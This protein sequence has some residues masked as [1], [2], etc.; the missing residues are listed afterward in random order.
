MVLEDRLSTTTY[1]MCNNQITSLH[2]LYVPHLS[3]GNCD[4]PF[5]ME[6][7]VHL[8]IHSISQ[9]NSSASAG[10]THYS[11]HHGTYNE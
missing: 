10:T 4:C 9:Q 7:L 6:L 2:L 5:L 3:Y 1:F 11:R 8:L